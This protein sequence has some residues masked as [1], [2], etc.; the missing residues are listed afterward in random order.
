MTL[1]SYSEKVIVKVCGF[2]DIDQY[3]F[4]S[5][6]THRLSNI[7]IPVFFLNAIDDPIFG[8]DVIP[9]EANHENVLIGTTEFG[10]HLGYFEGLLF[11]HK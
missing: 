1:T 7:Q 3:Y 6:C 11:P 5:S 9:K 4:E 10:G 8:S 2:K